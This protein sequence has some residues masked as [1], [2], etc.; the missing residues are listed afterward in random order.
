[1][2][3]LLGVFAQPGLLFASDTLYLDRNFEQAQATDHAWIYEDRKH[4]EE[5]QAVLNRTFK[6][7]SMPYLNFGFST[8]AYW[9]KIVMKNVDDLPWRST[10]STRTITWIL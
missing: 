4:D 10:T 2:I 9:L 6:E 8:S 7:H 5:L 3:C 1:M